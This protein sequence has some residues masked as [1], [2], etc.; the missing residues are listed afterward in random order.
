MK[1]SLKPGFTLAEVLIALGIMGVISAIMIPT[2]VSGT[3]NKKLAASLGRSVEAI[4]SGC[5]SLIQEAS[6]LSQSGNNGSQSGNNGIFF[7]HSYINKN[8]DGTDSGGNVSNSVIENNNLFGNA[9]RFFNTRQLTSEQVNQYG[10]R[11]KAF[12]GNSPSPNVQNISGRFFV[13]SKLGAYWGLKRNPNP[14]ND[15]MDQRDPIMEYVYVDVNGQNSP[16]R[17]GLDIFLF[18]LTDSCHMIPAG[19]NRLNNVLSSVPVEDA[20][21]GCKETNGV[22]DVVNGLSC[23]HRVVRD[24]YKIEYDK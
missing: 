5:Q 7:G 23:T 2:L 20:S 6:E 13:N 12:N 3:Q 22:I 19:T 21:N 1:K 16:N 17:Y 9:A 10:P 18:G 8:I 15:T 11:V 4:E 14:D 24:G